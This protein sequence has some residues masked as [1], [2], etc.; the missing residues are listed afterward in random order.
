M[1]PSLTK[2]IKHK[3][4]ITRKIPVVATYR[5]V[6]LTPIAARTFRDSSLI[7]I[8]SV[9]AR[10]RIIC[11]VTVH[12][13]VITICHTTSVGFSNQ[14]NFPELLQVMSAD[15]GRTFGYHCSKSAD[16]IR[17]VTTDPR[18]DGG[19]KLWHYF[20]HLKFHT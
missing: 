16:Q 19:P 11:T 18:V 12:Y 20:F 5:S 6:D 7:A 17:V 10:I 13:T 9:W 3:N 14:A 2:A 15:N 1:G 4:K 8:F